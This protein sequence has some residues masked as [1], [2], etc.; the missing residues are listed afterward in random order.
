MR[1]L[2]FVLIGLLSLAPVQFAQ[3]SGSIAGVIL[4]QS[5]SAIPGATVGLTNTE[6]NAARSALTNDAGA[7]SFPTLP[8]GTYN[9]KAEKTGF[10]TLVQRQV[11]I[12]VQQN[13]RIDFR[14][15]VGQVTESI[16]VAAG[17]ETIVTENAT[18]GTVIENKRIVDLPLNGRNYTQLV[19]LAPNVSAGFSVQGQAG[20]RQG[21]I[22]AAQAI[23]VA[24]QRTNFNH[25]TLDG[26]ENT[27]PN[28]N[29]FVVLP[30]IDALQEF[31][32]QTGIYPAEFGRQTT[33]INVLSKS[34]TNQYHGTAFEFLRND[35]LDATQ[36]AFTTARPS[37]DPFKW[38]QY[39]FTLGGPVRIP[40]LFNGRDK[41]FFMG[42]YE[43]FRKRGTATGSFSL[44]PTAF[45]TGD[46]SSSSNLIYD[47][48]TRATAAD[49]T[50]TGTPFVGNIIP[51]TRI[52]PTS[53]KLLEFYAKPT[54][55]GVTNNYLPA[56]SRPQ[57]R[58]QFTLRMDYVESAKSTWAGRYSW[59]D[60]NEA[61]PGIGQSGGKLI[62]NLEQYMGSNTRI[63]SPS[64]V[65]ETRFGYTRFYNSL[66]TLLAFQRNVVDELNIPGLKGGAPVSWGIPAIG[67]A[68]YSGIGDSTDGPFENKDNTLQFLNN[69]SIIKGK[70]SIRFGGEIRRDQYN[71]VGNQF[72]RG[73]FGFSV[74]PTQDPKALAAGS[75]LPT[76]GDAFASFLLGN[77]TLTEVAAQ[78]AAAQFRATTFALY[79]DDSW[80]VTPKFTV[81]VGL[82]YENTPP[83]EDQTGNLVTVFFNAYD[84]TP[85]VADQSRYPVFL[86][87]GK[88]TGDPYAGL[89]VKWPNIPLVQDGRLGNSLVNR[90]NND[91]AP[92]LGLAWSPN[93]KWSVRTGIGMFYNQ[94]QGN[95]WFD[96]ARNA[97]GRTRN[98]DNSSA[99]SETWD[100]GAAAL[101]GSVANIL[102]PQAFSM[103]FDRRTPYSVQWLLNVEHEIA[104][105]LTFEAGYLGSVSRHLESYRGTSAAVPGPGTIASRSPYPNFGLLVLV[106]DGGRGNYNSLGTKL[107]KRYSNGVTA[108]V[109]YT[110]SK[111]IDT[112]SGI[113]T[114]NSDTLFSQDGRC[115]LCDRGLSAFDNRHRLV[116]S[117]LY[118]LPFGDRRKY[119][120][121][122][123]VLN[124]IAGG[125]QVGG[126]TSW[127]AGFPINPSAG[128]NRAN[129][130]INSD[131]PDATG[132]PVSLDRATTEKWFN[133][134]AFALQPTFQF[135]N[136]A[137][138]SIMGPA[139]FSIDSNVQKN[140]RMP[141]EGHELQFRWEA[142]NLLNHPVWGFPNTNFSSTAFGS[143]NS[144]TTSMRQ[145]QFALK[146]VF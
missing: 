44:A 139:G 142:Y 120:I 91:F 92:R 64:V 114:S 21:G 46:F 76:Q 22:R 134:A 136:A 2:W 50:L 82:R 53:Q 67:I 128:Q 109:S 132:L 74:T 14:L 69:T 96:V 10:K 32:V 129:T 107:T 98:D 141:W 119:G 12:Q 6:T 108:L 19:S 77:V 85:N 34:G 112:T 28:F 23:S 60:E 124:A 61:T 7:Y 117:G 11:E 116:V 133:T 9:L 17:T 137:R 45:Q 35:K 100:N 57:N 15:E 13:A 106:D 103:K 83:W 118:D 125:W 146:Y 110:W 135:G 144:T 38:N 111:S 30:S 113:R 31:K 97:A 79:L 80:K 5:G 140:F 75:K 87:Q 42:N 47:P 122:N 81:S 90:D 33:Q 99:P 8:P 25:Y 58:D 37:K 130:N 40:K 52:H 39:G 88:G 145:M 143:I 36:Y 127:R 27:D 29:T 62:T 95:P 4:D 101:V 78:I 71:Q 131:R 72:G 24:G 93:P 26:V 1:S 70:H 65:N 18:V 123:S 126:I 86:R 104:R 3:T 63:L 68:N 51:T 54:L 43:S 102:T 73:S 105:D 49:G 138:N 66:G 121:K 94:D 48:R 59:S 55:P 84:N 56:F 115:M 16:E 20:A 41:L 89:R